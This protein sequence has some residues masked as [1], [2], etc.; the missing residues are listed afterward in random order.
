MDEF[1]KYA[2][3]PLIIFCIFIAGPQ[4]FAFLF[5]SHT[6]LGIVA[7]VLLA[8]IGVGYLFSSISGKED[9]D[10]VS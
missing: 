5:N 6:T 3:I 2:S 9:N 4:V 10:E 1:L 7:I 8:C